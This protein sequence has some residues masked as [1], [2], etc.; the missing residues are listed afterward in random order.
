MLEMAKS[1]LKIA[2][3]RPKMAKM[4]LKMA[5]M[6]LK[7]ANMRLKIAKMRP[8]MAKM[9]PKMAKMGPKMAKMKAKSRLIIFCQDQVYARAKRGHRDRGRPTAWRPMSPVQELQNSREARLEN[10]SATILQ[11][12]L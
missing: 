9:R 7:M 6:R 5:K 2:K 3:M 1:R 11:R 4:R 10:R 8:K 12:H